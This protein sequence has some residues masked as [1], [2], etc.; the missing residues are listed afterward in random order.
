MLLMISVT[1]LFLGP[2]KDLT[3]VE[4]V[5]LDLRLGATVGDARR[6]LAE[7]FPRLGGGLSKMRL[8]LNQ[9][10][11]VDTQVLRA[12]DELAVVPPVSGG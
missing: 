5:A 7:R 2:A 1:V 12:G 6:A 11:V 10:F 9:E 4:S 8:A 3:R